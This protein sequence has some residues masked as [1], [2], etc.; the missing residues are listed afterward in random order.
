MEGKETKEINGVDAEDRRMRISTITTSHRVI[1]TSKRRD[2]CLPHSEGKR[3]LS[4][5]EEKDRINKYLK[6][7]IDKPTR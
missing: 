5:Q 4:H 3:T 2:M 1:D 7:D 6:S